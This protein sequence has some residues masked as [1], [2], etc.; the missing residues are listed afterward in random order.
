M[1][2]FV[3]ASKVV[4]STLDMCIFFRETKTKFGMQNTM[5]LNI[6]SCV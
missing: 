2:A 6:S 3:Y 4:N 5:K 1:K